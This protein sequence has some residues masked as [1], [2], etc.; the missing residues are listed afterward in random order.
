MCSVNGYV[1]FSDLRCARQE[2]ERRAG[3]TMRRRGPDG[4][5]MHA[6][7]GVCFYHNRLAV[8]DVAGGKQPMSATFRGKRYTVAYNG[9]I[10]NSGELRREL[11]GQG[12]VFSTA[13]DT[14]TVLWSYIIYGEEAPCHL[15]GIF[16]FA[17]HDE[18]AKKVFFARDRMGVKPLFYATVG[19]RFYFASEIKALLAHGEIP[20]EVDEVGLWQLLYLSP[21][22]LP[23]QSVFKHV[24][25]LLP[26]W[27]A[28]LD[29]GGFKARP[30]WQLEARE[31]HDDRE[32]A[33]GTVRTLF[34]DA[35][36]RQLKSDVPL[37]VLLSGGLDSSAIAAV[38]S[39]AMR[40]EG[41]TLDTYS[42]E[43]EKND[44][45]F[46]SDLFLTGRDEAYAGALADELGTAHRV[47]TAPTARVA[48]LLREAVLARDMPGQA[49]IDSSLI[50]FCGEIKKRHT[51]VLS[52]ECSDEIFGGYPWF[53]RPEMLARD[54]FPW[55]HDPHTRI[56]LFDDGVVHAA[57]GFEYMKE[58]YAA[59][60]RAC[61][62]LDGDSEDM[63]T[64]RRATWLSTRYFMTNLLSRKDRMSMYRSVEVRV[65]FADHRIL[66]Y[67]FN[68]PWEYKFEGGVE[69]SLLRHAMEGYLPARVL[70]RKKSPYP[71]TQDPAYETAVRSV[72]HERLTSANGFLASTLK[73]DRLD[74][75]LAGGGGTWFGQLM[76]K[77]QLLAW[78]CQLD[79]WFEAYGVRL[80]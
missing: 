6:E 63:R 64:S 74:D 37:A 8:M 19:G 41:K 11:M 23:G 49:D 4:S 9:E 61:P 22:T 48:Q 65:P 70:W 31:C 12:A 17:V 25:E 46:R 77:P 3:D 80:V 33:I 39:R 28:T 2:V 72:L 34:V 73:R 50:Y 57:R 13:C 29:E 62:V 7:G 10:Y 54:F 42:F 47:L 68:L 27:S 14:E 44:E 56:G 76:A 36:E 35:V 79:F 71:K 45:Y 24:K 69:K 30:F 67:V 53:Y 1:D 58:A 78:L 38:A 52:G 55:Q 5:G 20:P 75:L 18:A 60:L 51:V 32:T 26:G 40:R 66:E 21:V 15:N 16:A 59:A 43:Y